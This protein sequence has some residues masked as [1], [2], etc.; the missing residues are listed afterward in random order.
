MRKALCFLEPIGAEGW[1]TL[2]LEPLLKAAG[3]RTSQD[4]QDR[5]LADVIFSSE[6]SD[7]DDRIITLLSDNAIAEQ[8]PGIAISCDDQPALIAA[9]EARARRAA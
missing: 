6:S 3:Y 9:I 7:D 5:S 1:E 2:I 8:K 4:P